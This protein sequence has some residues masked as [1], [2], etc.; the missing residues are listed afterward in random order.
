MC[1]RDSF[2]PGRRI[3]RNAFLVKILK[4]G[5]FQA[6]YQVDSLFY[7][8]VKVSAFESR[9]GPKQCYNCQRYGHSSIYCHYPTRCIRCGEGHHKGDCPR[10]RTATA[11]CANCREPHP[12]S[13][14]QCKHYHDA[15]KRI[16][17]AHKPTPP[18]PKK[19]SAPASA[20]PAVASS[21]F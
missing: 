8:R 18:A 17:K 13:S 12:A 7:L 14:R 21:D 5:N 3:P 16:T 1:I 11:T 10:E 9:P 4:V 2:S 6:I 20:A 15:L 19:P